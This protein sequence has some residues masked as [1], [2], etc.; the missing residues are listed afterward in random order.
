MYAWPCSDGPHPLFFDY[1]YESVRA[2]KLVHVR[3]WNGVYGGI[4]SSLDGSG[5]IHGGSKSFGLGSN[6]L[7]GGSKKGSNIMSA[8]GRTT[9][10]T[11]HTGQD[12]DNERVLVVE[13][14]GVPDN[15]VLARAWCAHWG[16]SAV[17][18]DISKTW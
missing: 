13:A 17:V 4:N 1:V 14:F 15:E 18:A 9:T 6:G 16:L 2:D 10:A 11:D 5:M 8:G 3:D 12:Q 7:G